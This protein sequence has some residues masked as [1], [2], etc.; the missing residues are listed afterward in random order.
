[1][2]HLVACLAVVVVSLAA[3]GS[4]RAQDQVTNSPFELQAQ[5]EGGIVNA[6]DPANLVE[7]TAIQTGTVNGKTFPYFVDAWGNPLRFF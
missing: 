7:P 3:V 2:R 5:P 6:F 4:A 1:M